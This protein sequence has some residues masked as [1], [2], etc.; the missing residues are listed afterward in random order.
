MRGPEGCGTKPL[1]LTLSRWERGHGSMRQV[2]QGGDVRDVAEVVDDLRLASTCSVAQRRRRHQR[3]VFGIDVGP[4]DAG[5][6]CPLRRIDG[7]REGPA[8]LRAEWS[9]SRPACTAATLSVGGAPTR[10][11]SRSCG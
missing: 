2:G 1:T 9:R 8:V 4:V 10:T 6:A 11:L 5:S 7:I 3:A